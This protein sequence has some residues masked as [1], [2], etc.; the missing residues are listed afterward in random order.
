MDL[1]R[2]WW[3]ASGDSAARLPL[4]RRFTSNSCHQLCRLSSC[5][6]RI[7]RSFCRSST[8][9]MKLRVARRN[10]FFMKYPMSLLSFWEMHCNSLRATAPAFVGK[11]FGDGGADPI[12]SSS[13]SSS[14]ALGFERPHRH[15][16]TTISSRSSRSPTTAPLGE[17]DGLF[18]RLNNRVSK[19]F[20]LSYTPR[21]NSLSSRRACDVCPARRRSSRRSSFD[22]MLTTPS[23]R[24][25]A[26]A[27]G[28]L[29]RLITPAMQCARAQCASTLNCRRT[30]CGDMASASSA[31]SRNCAGA[32]RPTPPAACKSSSGSVAEMEFVVLFD[33]LST[34]TS[35]RTLTPPDNVR[36]ALPAFFS[37]P[38]S[39]DW[40]RRL[41]RAG[42]F[43]SPPPQFPISLPPSVPGVSRHYANKVQK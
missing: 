3:N 13:S 7:E 26:W 16:S 1:R 15:S 38:R 17:L 30:L 31:S 42:G 25:A 11:L 43:S 21:T 41:L 24:A 14:I 32:I 6:R 29:S 35:S 33:E 2:H 5:S 28:C 27:S 8:R 20:S 12:S 18:T 23:F 34:L 40:G 10:P 39:A 36:S 4:T 22:P 37:P 19:S 9:L